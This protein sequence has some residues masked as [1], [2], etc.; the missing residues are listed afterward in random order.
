M[1]ALYREKVRTPEVLR[2]ALKLTQD[3]F[4]RAFISY[5]EAKARPLHQALRTEAKPTSSETKQDVLKRLQTE[6]TFALNLRAGN[7]YLADG[8]IEPAIRHLKRAIELFPYHTGEG[9]AYALLAEIFE[10]KG[11]IAQAADAVESMVKVDG[12][13]LNALKS[14]LR[15]RLA[16]GEQNKALEALK[17]S[18]Y[19]DPFNYALHTQAGELSLEARDYS[20]AL[21]E[22]Q[23]ALALKPPN[24][25]E[26]NYNLAIAYHALG[27]Q[28]EAKRS[29]LRALEAAPR[30]EKAQEL[31]LRITGQ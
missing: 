25:A 1:L 4:D 12:N 9:S 5:V 28:P 2:Q 18:F 20:Q 7:L 23:S 6:D 8:E 14:L 17:L 22:F 29:V 24:V 19:V 15:L 11:D 31:L 10:K 30:Y 13:N 26:A 27:R 21:L 3:E 16:Q